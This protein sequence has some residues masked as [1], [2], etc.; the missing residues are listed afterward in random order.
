M[1]FQLLALVE[2]ALVK[3]KRRKTPQTTSSDKYRPENLA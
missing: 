1:W 2:L 3:Y